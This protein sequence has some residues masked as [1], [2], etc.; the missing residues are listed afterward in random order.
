[1]CEAGT[2]E[3]VRDGRVA[4]AALCASLLLHALQPNAAFAVD[5]SSMT[6]G[7]ASRSATV[8]VVGSM[9]SDNNEATAVSTST[10]VR[11]ARASSL[12][13]SIVPTVQFTCTVQGKLSLQL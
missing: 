12:H 6:A 7:T 9:V 11:R 1:M 3:G 8:E 13:M 10:Q 5:T 4:A 2:A